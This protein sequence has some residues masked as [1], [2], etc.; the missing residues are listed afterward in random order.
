MKSRGAG[1]KE[2]INGSNNIQSNVDV[3]KILVPVIFTLLYPLHSIE[4]LCRLCLIKIW[5]LVHVLKLNCMYIAILSI[6][7]FQKII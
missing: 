4:I 5:G 6:Q 2:R 3:L 1:E 7:Y